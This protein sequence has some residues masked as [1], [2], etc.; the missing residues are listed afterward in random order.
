ME[1]LGARGFTLDKL[2]CELAREQFN[3]AVYCDDCWLQY[4]VVYGIASVLV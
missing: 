4:P 2:Y 1:F 3:L